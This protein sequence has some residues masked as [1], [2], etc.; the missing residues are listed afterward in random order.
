MGAKCIVPKPFDVHLALAAEVDNPPAGKKSP[1]ANHSGCGQ[2]R[3]EIWIAIKLRQIAEGFGRGCKRLK[4]KSCE[5][6]SCGSS[7]A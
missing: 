2:R 4:R 3:D 7:R 1:E 6:S 5:V